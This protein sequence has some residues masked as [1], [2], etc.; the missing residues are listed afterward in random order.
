M[1]RPTFIQAGFFLFVFLSGMVYQ[2]VWVYE[3]FWYRADFYDS[4]PFNVPYIIFLLAYSTLLTAVAWV[5]V[6]FAKSKL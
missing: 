4:I 5:F 1:K 6:K 2:P 3:N